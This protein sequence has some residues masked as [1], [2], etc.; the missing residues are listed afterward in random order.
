MIDFALYR[1]RIGLFNVKRI[2]LNKEKSRLGLRSLL[3][4][5]WWILFALIAISVGVLLVLFSNDWANLE[6]LHSNIKLH[7]YIAQQ[8]EIG[9]KYGFISLYTV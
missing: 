3:G 4:Y 8:C 7:G 6:Y 5:Y 2:H 1:A 9:R